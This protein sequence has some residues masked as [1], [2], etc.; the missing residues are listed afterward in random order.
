[1]ASS[2]YADWVTARDEYLEALDRRF[3][4]NPYHEQTRR[5]RD[6][7]LLTDAERRVEYLAA[8]VPTRFSNP[9][10][11]AEGAFVLAHAAA[12]FS[13]G[14]RDDLGALKKWKEMAA[15]LNPDDPEERK[16]YLVAL[17]RVE[18]LER[19]IR[20]RRKLVEEQIRLAD[21][22]RQAGRTEASTTIISK[23]KD[24]YKDYTDLIELLASLP[25]LPPASPLPPGSP[26]APPQP[27]SSPRSE[28][29][30]SEKPAPE[31]AASPATDRPAGPSGPRG[32]APPATPGP[33]AEPGPATAGIAG[34]R[35]VNAFNRS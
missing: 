2:R 6:K 30:S 26:A 3:P 15:K 34:D 35:R 33:A 21:E 23:L 13:S 29:A 17:H 28:D 4:E 12:G 25:A 19:T 5:W 11:D 22:F 1:M 10:N 16:W 31:K 7:I 24:Q 14:Q 32:E 18:Q 20:D 8:P 9:T 27:S